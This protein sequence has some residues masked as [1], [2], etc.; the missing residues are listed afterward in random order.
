MA[1]CVCVEMLHPD[2]A[3]GASAPAWMRL[4]V[5]VVVVVEEEEL[6]VVIDC[7]DLVVV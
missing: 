3:T 2:Y 5:L 6:V 7:I 1:L 4:V